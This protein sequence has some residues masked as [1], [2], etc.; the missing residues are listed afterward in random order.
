MTEDIKF[1]QRFV[2]SAV[3]HVNEDHRDAMIDILKGLRQANW[4]VDAE[5]VS[6]DKEKIEAKG[7]E[8]IRKQKILKFCST[9][10]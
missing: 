3:D 1:E 6:F 10:L 7:L 2:D 5:L 9:Y 4:V 8:L